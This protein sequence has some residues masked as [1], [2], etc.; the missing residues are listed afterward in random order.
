MSGMMMNMLFSFANKFMKSNRRAPAPAPANQNNVQQNQN[1]VQNSL[2]EETIC[3]ESLKDQL[4]KNLDS[5]M[6]NDPIKKIDYILSHDKNGVKIKTAYEILNENDEA[7]NIV[8]NRP[9][10]KNLKLIRIYQ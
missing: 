10:R 8:Q 3:E 1:V 2:K 9:R 6:E 7:Q 5:E 4:N